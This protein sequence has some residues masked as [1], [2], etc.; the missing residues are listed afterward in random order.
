MFYLYGLWYVHLVDFHM[1]DAPSNH[2][3]IVFL[4][5]VK[6]VCGVNTYTNRS[7]YRIC[8]GNNAVYIN[9]LEYIKCTRCIKTLYITF[10]AIWSLLSTPVHTFGLVLCWSLLSSRSLWRRSYSSRIS[11]GVLFL[12]TTWSQKIGFECKGNGGLAASQVADKKLQ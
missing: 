10:S 5:V 9:N 4:I 7:L 12:S 8:S 6:E 1:W 11:A 3:L 2:I